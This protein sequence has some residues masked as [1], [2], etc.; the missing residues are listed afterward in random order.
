MKYFIINADDFG[1]NKVATQNILTCFENYRITSTSAMVFM[2][3]SER[4]AYLAR[5]RKLNVGL[6]V[7]FTHG[8][9]GHIPSSKLRESQRKIIAF[10]SKG[11]YWFLVYNPALRDEFKFVYDA[12]YEEFVR[13]YGRMPTHVDGHR[14]MH[15]CTNMLVDKIIAEGTKVRRNFSFALGEKNPFNLGYRKLVDTWLKRRY[16]CTDFF[17]SISPINKP[18]RMKMIIELAKSYVVE[19]MV[20]PEKE[21]EQ[22]YIMSKEYMY[23]FN[24]NIVELSSIKN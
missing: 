16:R 17:F 24:N 19:M 4:A 6:H 11:K 22:N 12:Q 8:F 15:L 3:D 23:I 10:L 20:H 18:S 7:N 9:T 5:D 13:L 1:S 21:E 2:E 14:H